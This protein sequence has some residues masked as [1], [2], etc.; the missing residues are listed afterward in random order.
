MFLMVFHF[1]KSVAGGYI[2]KEHYNG[3]NMSYENRS[4]M[5]NI[6]DSQTSEDFRLE[7]KNE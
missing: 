1:T 5:N 7:S 6:Y 4:V 3:V 2:G